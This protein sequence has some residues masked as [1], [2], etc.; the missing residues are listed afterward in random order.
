M[1]KLPPARIL[2][3][4]TAIMAVI[5]LA[6]TASAQD[7]LDRALREASRAGKAQRVIV[8]SKPGYEA[9][10][11]KLLMQ[12]G[13]KIHA[14]LPSVRGFAV[15]LTAGELDVICSSTAFDGCSDDASVT[16]TAA[17][18]ARTTRT[19][20]TPTKSNGK[21]NQEPYHAPAVSTLLATLGLAPY[22][23]AGSGVT[24]ALIDSGIH[25]S[26][27]FG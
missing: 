11:R 18:K 7:K 21:K 17:A 3:A 1:L 24:V 4:L 26:P 9:W 8:K 16:T 5:G 14:E 15:E 13:K 6:D 25:P 10:G 19:R 12:K 27:A 2:V 20:T 23:W 22:D